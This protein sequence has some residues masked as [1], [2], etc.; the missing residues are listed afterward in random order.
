MQTKFQVCNHS[1]E[2][3]CDVPLMF[4]NGITNLWEAIVIQKGN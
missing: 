1:L 4:Y 2:D 3:Q